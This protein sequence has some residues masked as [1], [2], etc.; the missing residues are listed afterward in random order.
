MDNALT[1][2]DEDIN[3]LRTQI[4][5]HKKRQEY[6]RLKNDLFNITFQANHTLTEFDS[7]MKQ[8]D[9]ER[10]LSSPNHKKTF[11]EIVIARLIKMCSVRPIIGNLIAVGLAMVSIFSMHSFLNNPDLNSLKIYLSYFIELAAGIQILK[12][13][14]RSLILP[15]FATLIGA[16]IANKLTGNHLFLKHSA[17]FYQAVLVTG[18]IGVA[19]SVFSID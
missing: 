6:E 12:S 8:V 16:I 9:T 4:N 11:S 10:V 13:A 5:E 1:I 7:G 3:E 17:E 19:I 14:S 18:L 15:I 2:T